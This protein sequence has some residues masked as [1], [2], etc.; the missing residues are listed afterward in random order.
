MLSDRL[1]ALMWFLCAIV[2]RYE[3]TLLTALFYDPIFHTDVK[4][5]FFLV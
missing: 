5:K 1:I 4:T 2:F 3:I